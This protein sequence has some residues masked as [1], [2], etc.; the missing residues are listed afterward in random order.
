MKMGTDLTT[1]AVHSFD[2][3]R[4]KEILDEWEVQGGG[5]CTPPAH[6]SIE[7]WT[8]RL[9]ILAFAQQVWNMAEEHTLNHLMACE[10]CGNVGLNF[11]YVHDEY[12]GD[13]DVHC[14]ECGHPGTGEASEVLNGLVSRV[15][16]LE[17]LYERMP[18]GRDLGI[19]G[20]FHEKS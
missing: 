19:E 4:A 7:V 1:I 11:T 14:D 5:N 8:S 18:R 12:N 9:G 13:G 17:A 10:G 20:A 2:E 16:E 6:G 3:N 15:D